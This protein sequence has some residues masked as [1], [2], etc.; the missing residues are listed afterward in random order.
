M[1]RREFVSWVGVGAIA[2]SLPVA[3]AACTPKTT[4]VAAPKEP[5]RPDGFQPVGSVTELDQQGFIKT[6]LPAGVATVIR[7]PTN[8]IQL[9][10]VN[11]ACTHKGCV[12]DWKKADNAFVC[13]CHDAKF[14]ADGK[15]TGGPADKPLP[16]YTAKLD[17]DVVLIKPA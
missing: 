7:N 15:V 3:L 13:P 14:A 17:G 8:P 12:V 9:M 2:T 4:E 6:K 5:V 10:A 16:T 1:N 11:A